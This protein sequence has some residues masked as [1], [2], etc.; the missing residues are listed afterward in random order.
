VKPGK[1]PSG[2]GLGVLPWETT[3][4]AAQ[5]KLNKYAMKK[6]WEAIA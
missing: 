5:E 6:G 2:K 4:R 1:N 3:C